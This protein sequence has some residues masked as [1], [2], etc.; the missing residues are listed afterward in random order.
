M[1]TM[2]IFLKYKSAFILG[3]TFISNSLLIAVAALLPGSLLFY[4]LG[5][6]SIA[7]NI[8][9][10]LF[11]YTFYKQILHIPQVVENWKKGNLTERFINI[12]NEYAI[13]QLKW[14]LNSLIDVIDAL[15]R[16]TQGS[17]T[18]I[19]EG[20]F[21]RKI[22]SAG[23]QGSFN[24]NAQAINNTVQEAQERNKKLKTAGQDFENKIRS[25]LKKVISSANEANQHA[26]SLCNLSEMTT[27]K[28]ES[29]KSNTG[30]AVKVMSDLL[31]AS[32]ELTQAIG[33]I[34]YQITESNNITN[35]A[36]QQATEASETI[37]SLKES[38]QEINEIIQLISNIADQ[39]NLLAL[40]AT[41]EAAR[42]GEAGK[43]FAVVASEVKTLATQT[44]Q[45]T[46]KI[47]KQI[48]FVQ[49]YI[50]KTVTAIEKIIE[51]ILKMGSISNA[52]AAAVEEQNATT[53]QI[54]SQMSSSKAGITQVNTDMHEIRDVASN[55]L[56][57]S[58]IVNKQ[59]GQLLQEISTLKV[60][61]EN[62]GTR[63]RS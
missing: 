39:T 47:T 59:I 20:R 30:D 9:S 28:A 56:S 31:S 21:Y 8:V 60:D 61:I 26:E 27:E 41:I 45:A 10:A 4:I 1:T 17:M 44:V 5:V 50:N 7:V 13:H 37:E 52:V 62:F 48:D 53:K 2:N 12:E 15:C 22:L 25:A 16:E 23:L 19:E 58:N 51:T 14:S 36:T 54:N 55:T 6:I 35:Q 32:A 43:G 57:S 3:L 40:N 33:E 42:A 29:S 38:S 34:S 49:G 11:F 18:A 63:L 24:N 46:D